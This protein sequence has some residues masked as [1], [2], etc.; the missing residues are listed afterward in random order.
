[1]KKA[2]VNHPRLYLGVITASLGLLTIGI[3]PSKSSPVVGD[4]MNIQNPPVQ[5]RPSPVKYLGKYRFYQNEPVSISNINVQGNPVSI[6]SKVTVGDDWLRNLSFDLQNIS[7][8][9]IIYVSLRL[10]FPQTAAGGPIL[11]YPMH[12]GERPRLPDQARKQ[13]PLA[14]NEKVEIHINDDA[15]TKL[16]NFVETRTPM[17]NISDVQIDV[18]FVAFDDDTAWATGAFMHRKPGNPTRW[19]DDN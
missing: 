16:K 9:R 6:N 2:S 15:Y 18:D 19:V 1:M 7:N 10:L 4:S 12:Y 5:S 17:A 11:A 8:K 14:P 3:F 13:A